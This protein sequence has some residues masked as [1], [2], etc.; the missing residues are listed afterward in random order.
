MELC[1]LSMKRR[2]LVMWDSTFVALILALRWRPHLEVLFFTCWSRTNC[3]IDLSWMVL[4]VWVLWII[5]MRTSNSLPGS[6]VSLHFFLVF[7][8]QSFFSDQTACQNLLLTAR[9]EPCR[10]SLVKILSKPSWSSL[11]IS[12]LPFR[13]VCH[14]S[15]TS[16][17]SLLYIVFFLRCF[18][19]QSTRTMPEIVVSFGLS[20]SLSFID[21]CLFLVLTL[22]W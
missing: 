10:F 11:A 1:I 17:R 22:S 13:F 19:R 15:F 7:V 21:R 20:F 6:A 12:L 2:K 8:G 18:F 16:S 5:S 3:L 4:L 9:T 14:L